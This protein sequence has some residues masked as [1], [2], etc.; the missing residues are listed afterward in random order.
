MK[1]FQI[2]TLIVFSFFSLCNAQERV[3]KSEVFLNE[4][5]KS[6][7][8]YQSVKDSIER[9][10]LKWM[11]NNN[12]SFKED[13]TSKLNKKSKT[14]LNSTGGLC[15]YNNTFFTSLNAP[16]V[17]N[18]II[19][20][21]PNCTWGGEYVRVNNLVAGNTYR[22]STIGLN[23]FDTQITIYPAGGGSAVAYNDDWNNSLQSAIYFSPLVSGNYDILVNQFG[24]L[25]NQLCASLEIELWYI[26]RPVI[27]IPV[28]VHIIHKGEAIGV[29]TNISDAQ[30]LSQIN[31]LNQDFRRLNPDIAFTPP[32]FRGASVDPL[33]Q[34]CLAQQKPDGTPTNGII[35]IQEPSEQDYIS[36]GVPPEFRCINRLTLESLI[37]PFTIWDRDKYLN[38]WVSELKELPD[39]G[40]CSQISNTLG[41]AQFPGMGGI[42]SPTIPAH[43][44]DGVFV[45]YDVFGTIG[46]LI[47]NFNLGRT[48]THEIGHWL[49][50]RHIWGDEPNCTQDDF[51]L[52]T[53]LQADKSSGCFTFPFLDSCSNNYPGI[54]FMN[55]M[56]YSDD[57][58]L[59]MF[60]F[61]QSARMDSALFTLRASLLNSQGCQPSTLS[62]NVNLLK[63]EI[64]VYPNPFWDVINIEAT[65]TIHKIEIYN[66]LGQ[67]VKSF[68]INPTISTTLE[69]NELPKG[70]YIGKVYF[71]QNQTTIKLT[72][73]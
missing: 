16:T 48:A 56:D 34:F 15:P 60:T 38:I 45:R 7:P 70:N 64:K 44:T 39:D 30:I 22:I 58:C 8:E 43:Q 42:Y 53:P 4:F 68:K 55:F 27:T 5:L 13:I 19:T 9:L 11:Q 21:S 31:K 17:L 33:I 61:G 66:L 62:S 12:R 3:C 25:S 51:V 71:E 40:G 49:N 28:V 47:P 50:L 1:S 18:Q 35:R 57:N 24:C 41:Y 29:G 26:P 20:P 52:D 32:A 10:S 54:M 46:N 69:L 36:Q 65:Q 14:T 23:N 37:K 59:S 73:N 6:N 72:K 2:L 63:H 67:L